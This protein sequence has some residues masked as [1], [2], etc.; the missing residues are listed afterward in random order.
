MAVVAARDWV[1]GARGR[2]APRG[3]LVVVAAAARRRGGGCRMVLRRR[4]PPLRLPGA[5]RGLGV[6]VLRPGRR[7][8]NRVRAD[9]PDA[10]ARGGGLGA[11][12]PA[13][14]RA[15]GDQ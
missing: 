12:R 5:W 3:G 9:G 7:G 4:P 15:A 1:A 6:P 10:V 2:P 13:R 11:G 14:L 8:G